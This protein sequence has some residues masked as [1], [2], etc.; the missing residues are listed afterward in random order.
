MRQRSLRFPAAFGIGQT[1]PGAKFLLFA[2]NLPLP[3]LLFSQ[4]VTRGRQALPP[5][6]RRL[7]MLSWAV[8]F[9]II[10]IIAG[11]LGF[12]GIAGTSAGIAQILFFIFLVL[13]IISLFRGALRR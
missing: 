12:G 11:V 7:P 8:T 1:P 13:F 2:G 4:I 5:D 9:L 6:R 3:Q 10:A